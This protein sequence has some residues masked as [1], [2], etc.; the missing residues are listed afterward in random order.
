[1][2]STLVDSRSGTNFDIYARRV[3]PCGE[4][5]GVAGASSMAAWDRAEL[6]ADSLPVPI[7]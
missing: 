3:L 7:V 6:E 5:P 1:L 4:L 2:A